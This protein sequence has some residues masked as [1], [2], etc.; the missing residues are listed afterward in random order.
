MICRLL[1]HRAS[2]VL[3]T[4]VVLGHNLLAS[5]TSN[6]KK[7]NKTNYVIWLSTISCKGAVYYIKQENRIENR[8]KKARCP[9]CKNLVIIFME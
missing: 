3:F 4:V 7:I 9:I 1:K 5:V 8:V 6:A 2:A